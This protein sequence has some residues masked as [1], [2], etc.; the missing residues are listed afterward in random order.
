M[1][2]IVY[3]FLIMG[4]AGFISSTVVL[5]IRVFVF[6]PGAVINFGTWTGTLL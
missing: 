6:F 5:R 3:S 4:D 1:G 2:I